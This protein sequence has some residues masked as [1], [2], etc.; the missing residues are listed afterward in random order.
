[1]TDLGPHYTPA[2]RFAESLFKDCV[3]EHFDPTSEIEDYFRNWIL[4]DV[5]GYRRSRRC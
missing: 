1:M 5:Q 4:S 2:Q 3:P